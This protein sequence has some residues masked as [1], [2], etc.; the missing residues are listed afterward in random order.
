MHSCYYPLAEYVHWY[1]HAPQLSIFAILFNTDKTMTEHVL[2]SECNA[3]QQQNRFQQ[4]G[5]QPTRLG[6]DTPEKEWGTRSF[7][8][9]RANTQ[10][11]F[12]SFIRRALGWKSEPELQDDA[13]IRIQQEHFVTFVEGYSSRKVERL[14]L[15]SESRNATAATIEETKVKAESNIGRGQPF[16]DLFDVRAPCIQVVTPGAGRTVEAQIDFDLVKSWMTLCSSEHDSDC[17][18]EDRK[19]SNP[20]FKV[21]DVAN[22]MVVTAPESCCFV[23]LSYVWGTGV[24]LLTLTESTKDRLFQRGGLADECSDVPTTI[25]DSLLVCEKLGISYLWVDA[26]C[27]QQ[28]SPEDLYLVQEMHKVYGGASFTI[29]AGSATT[30][31]GGLPGVSGCRSS[32]QAILELDGVIFATCQTPPQNF[33]KYAKWEQRGWTLQ[34]K[35]L[36]NRLL[37]FTEDQ[38][39][40]LCNRAHWCEDCCFEAKS[41][42]YVWPQ[43]LTTHLDDAPKKPNLHEMV[44]PWDSLL[45]YKTLVSEYSSRNLTNSSDAISAF[46]G[47]LNSFHFVQK[48][49]HHFGLPRS[50]FNIALLSSSPVYRLSSRRSQFPTWSWAGWTNSV[51][52]EPLQY[53]FDNFAWNEMRSCVNFYHLLGDCDGRLEAT[54]TMDKFY[55]LPLDQT[56]VREEGDRNECER[57]LQEHLLKL[58]EEYLQLS[59]FLIFKTSTIRVRLRHH[60]TLSSGGSCDY[61]VEALALEENGEHCMLALGSNLDRILTFDAIWADNT[62]RNLELVA[63]VLSTTND[64]TKGYTAEHFSFHVLLIETNEL[65]VSNKVNCPTWRVPHSIWNKAAPK[66]RVVFLV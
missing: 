6:L 34:E 38:I 27:I 42:T 5:Q 28:D 43:R 35:I 62:D 36:S 13:R 23:A 4:F 56:V 37:V 10:C 17:I 14:V 65:G 59:H 22:R 53:A 21:I 39:F 11:A 57:A 44:D 66:E 26:L 40:W 16:S 41:S 63:I 55:I 8:Y 48:H 2:C 19:I 52:G 15:M 49:S 33:M 24:P 50:F 9:L 64:F 1:W 58:K 29:V 25:R 12:C 61:V 31:W 51:S 47:V 46:V 32:P 7:Q 20:R 54:Q 3:W 18:L 60:G 30:S 45:A